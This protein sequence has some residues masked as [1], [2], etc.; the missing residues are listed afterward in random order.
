MKDKKNIEIIEEDKM[1]RTWYL[2]LK[3]IVFVIT[4][5][6]I[7]FFSHIS[8]GTSED[9]VPFYQK[10][11][12]SFLVESSL[13]TFILSIVPYSIGLLIE[14][15]TGVRYKIAKKIRIIEPIIYL[16][17]SV[18]FTLGFMYNTF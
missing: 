12:W 7:Y 3:T 13:I 8:I 5:M 2:L 11:F 18:V 14:R 15:L 9:R 17:L 6:G 16:V 10:I 1:L 4:V